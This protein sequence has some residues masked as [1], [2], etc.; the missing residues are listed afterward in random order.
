MLLSTKL[1][2][3]VYKLT[4]LCAK[5]NTFMQIFYVSVNHFLKAVE[6]FKGHLE[7]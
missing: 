5:V 3:A 4:Y 7:L 1:M 2:H 6:E